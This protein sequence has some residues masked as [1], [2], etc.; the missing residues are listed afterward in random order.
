MVKGKYE[1]FSGENK[2]RFFAVKVF[3]HNMQAENKALLKRLEIY[4]G[5]ETRNY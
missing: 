5:K 4:D 3:P 1:L 2:I